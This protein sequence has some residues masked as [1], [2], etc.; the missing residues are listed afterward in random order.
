MSGALDVHVVTPEREVWSGE[1]TTVIARGVDGEVGILTGHA[2]LMVQLAIG[3]LRVQREGEPELAAVIDG[4]FMHVT[5]GSAGD[6]GPGT[7]V[8]VLASHAELA[9]DIDLEAARARAAELEERFAAQAR[10]SELADADVEAMKVALAKVQ[11]RI[12]LAG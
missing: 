8:D 9:D 11:A 6:D 4:G 12:D 10:D 5:S 3:P 1:A 2:P 7:R